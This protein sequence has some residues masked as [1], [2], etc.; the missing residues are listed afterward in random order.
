MKIA[1][2]A[3]AT[4]LTLALAACG[5]S[6]D[7]A[8]GDAAAEQGEARAEVLEDSGMDDMA[9]RVEENGYAREEAIDDADVDADAMTPAQQNALVNGAMPV[10]SAPRD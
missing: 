5:G 2:T 7:D 1:A 3:I 4:A 6:G 9:E 10:E 8:L